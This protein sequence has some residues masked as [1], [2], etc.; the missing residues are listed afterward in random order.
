M[1]I[2]IDFTDSSG[3]KHKDGAGMLQAEVDRIV[4]DQLAA[5]KS[6][7]ESVRCDIHGETAT[8]TFSKT[9]GKASFQISGCCEDLVLRAEAAA[10]NI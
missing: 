7:I 10:D 2:E 5:M 6:A 1:D 3:R 8:V 9:A 4:D